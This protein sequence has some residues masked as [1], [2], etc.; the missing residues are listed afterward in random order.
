VR[1][2]RDGLVLGVADMDGLKLIQCADWVV[3]RHCP[4]PCL[5]DV[6][7]FGHGW[8]GSKTNFAVVLFQDGRAGRAD[9]VA[10]ACP[11]LRTSL[12]YV[13]NLGL[14]ALE[15]LAVFRSICHC[16]KYSVPCTVTLG[17]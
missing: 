17:V 14:A 2:S 12:A 7:E 1:F 9:L 11:E 16:H 10:T 15:D 6:E 13:P 8:L 3:V 5:I 4:A